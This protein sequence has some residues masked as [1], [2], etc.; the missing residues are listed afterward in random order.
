M[1]EETTSFKVYKVSE[2]VKEL[3]EWIESKFF[4][5]YVE[6]EIS[7]LRL[8]PSSHYI[9]TLKDEYS[10]IKAI[11]YR[12]RALRFLPILKDGKKVRIYGSV[13]LYRDRGEIQ[14]EVAAIE[15]IGLGEDYKKFLELKE[16]LE[17]EGIFDKKYKKPIPQIP[18]K[19]GIITSLKGAAVHDFINVMTRRFKKVHMIIFHSRVQGDGALEEIIEGINYF[20]KIERPDVIVITRGGGSKEDLRV[21]NEEAL[22]RAVFNSN[23]PVISAIGHHIDFTLLDFVA[24]SRAETPTAAAEMLSKHEV[25]VL[26]QLKNI[27]NRLLGLV[28]SKINTTKIRL[29]TMQNKLEKKNPERSLSTSRIKL[30]DLL[31]RMLSALTTKMSILRN[32]LDINRIRL[33]KSNPKQT[34]ERY[35][36]K[37][38]LIRSLIENLSPKRILDKGYAICYSEDGKIIK[39]ALNAREKS[40]IIVEL[41]KGTL[42]CKVLDRRLMI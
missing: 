15:E 37:V 24:D 22:V 17:K 16:K 20:N 1:K 23:I 35:K 4:T 36:E 30:D 31:S 25:D 14:L 40:N 34:I 6:G 10:Q 33:Q 29:F 39:S 32:S 41:Q 26:N 38:K 9:F 28:T 13:M 8:T 2:L 27:E 7:D 21:F 5:V 3:E 12:G 42:I 19:I 18:R 11:L